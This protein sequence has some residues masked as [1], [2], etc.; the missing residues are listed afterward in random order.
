MSDLALKIKERKK[1]L[2]E[3]NI[4]NTIKRRKMI[5]SGDLM[6]TIL[7][8]CLPLAL[9][10]LFNSSYTLLDQIISAQIS[11]DAQNAVSS[12][13]QIK[14]TI[15]AFGA[16]IA[17][18]GGVFV[19]RLYGSGDVNGSRKASSNLFF[20]SLIVSGLVMLIFIPLAVPIMRMC[21]IAD[22]SVNIGKTYFRLQMFELAFVSLN[23]VFIGLEKAKGNSKMILILNLLVLLVKLIFTNIFILQMGKYDIVFVELATICG[24]VFLTMIGL[25]FLFRKGNVIRLSLKMILP[26][27]EYILPI[28]KLSVPIFLGKFVM[29]AGKV[30]VNGMC[31]AYWNT[32]TDGLIVGTLGVSNNMCGLIT[33]PTNTFEEGESSVVS[34][35]LG[36]RNIKRAIRAFYKTLIVVTIISVIG[37]VLM[38][39]FKNQLVNLFTSADSKSEM[40]KQMV[41]EIFLFDSLSIPTLGVTAAV[42]GLLYGFGKTGLSTILNLSRIGS[43]IVFLFFVHLIAPN[44]SPT[45]CA[46]LSMGISN[47]IILLVSVGFLIYFLIQVKKKGF[48]GMYL[49]DEEPDVSELKLES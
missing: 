13:S 16:A 31:G 1:K 29:S 24:Q 42:L 4:E 7:I 18:G 19:S 6:K 41:K 38:H 33:S 36:N 49:T 40:Y 21:Q 28:L 10:Q 23:N 39:I 8:I 12:I 44:M 37:F 43:R 30:V 34:Q 11:T 22:E 5:L 20:L 17:A 35:N 9:Y 47:T 32:V 26:K 2:E 14:N 25:V 48:E 46:G 27:K 15:S 3:K 45:L